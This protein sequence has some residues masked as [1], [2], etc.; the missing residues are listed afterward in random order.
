VAN[1]HVLQE[2]R[3]TCRA[4]ALWSSQ[5]GKYSG[6]DSLGSRRSLSVERDTVARGQT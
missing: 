6:G 2:S 4:E 3:L 5:V 1:F